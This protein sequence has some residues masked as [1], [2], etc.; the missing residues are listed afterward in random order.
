MPKEK[1]KIA[2]LFEEIQDGNKV[3]F[4]ELFAQYITGY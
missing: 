4:E 2:R 3:A 1:L